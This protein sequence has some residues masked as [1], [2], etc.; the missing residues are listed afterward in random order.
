MELSHKIKQY[1]MVENNLLALS[2]AE[3]MEFYAYRCE[4]LGI[5]ME[6][7]P[8]DLLHLPASKKM[9][10]RMI[11]YANAGCAQ[12]LMAQHKLSSKIVEKWR[13]DDVYCVMVEVSGPDGRVSSN[14]GASG[15][16]GYDGSMLKGDQLGNSIMRAIT[17]ATRR[18]VFAHCGLNM[19]DETEVET[20]QGSAKVEATPTP[21]PTTKAIEWND[22]EI[23]EAK[24]CV[25]DFC[26]TLDSIGWDEE[27]IEKSKTKRLSDIG[28]ERGFENWM[29]R[30]KT[31][32][33]QYIV[34]VRQ[35]LA[36]RALAASAAQGGEDL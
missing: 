30:F 8:F 34:K 2:P 7:H 6:A 25:Y 4:Q 35:A 29:N 13:E 24:Q 26:D 18:T 17:K 20:I 21:A 3:R 5:S 28:D 12:Q 11:L 19:M 15:L 10:E 27:E 14:I 22:D 9:P 36:E 16:S 23:K 31:Y 1:A 33:D 32:S